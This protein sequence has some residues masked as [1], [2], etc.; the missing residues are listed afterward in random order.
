MRIEGEALD[1]RAKVEG[2]FQDEKVQRDLEK[3]QVDSDQ[4]KAMIERFVQSGHQVRLGKLTKKRQHK[5]GIKKEESAIAVLD[6]LLIKAQQREEFYHTRH[7][8]A[9]TG[10]YQGWIDCIKE[11]K[12][13]REQL[14]GAHW[15]GVKAVDDG[16]EWGWY[17]RELKNVPAEI[18][19]AVRA[20]TG[21][22]QRHRLGAYAVKETPKKDVKREELTSA[23]NE[24][25]FSEEKG[26]YVE[27]VV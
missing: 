15:D 12:K 21:F 19:R 25:L 18:E 5:K 22:E 9:K 8:V 13:V 11:E 10:M 17:K 3:R 27:S 6:D 16:V 1:L 14:M 2:L 24:A 4:E 7:E 26:E 20:R 23:L